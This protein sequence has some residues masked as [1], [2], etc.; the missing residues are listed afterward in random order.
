VQ[1]SGLVAEYQRDPD[2]AL[3]IRMIP[4]IAF[5]P[6][7]DVVATFEMLRDNLPDNAGVILD[8]FE[9]YIGRPRPNDAGRGNPFGTFMT[10]HL[11]TCRVQITTLKAGT[12]ASKPVSAATT[13]ISGVFSTF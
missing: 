11:K 1:N 9:G 7:E 6:E 5:V 8:Y 13:P 10:E 4:A 2:F 3:A 12:D